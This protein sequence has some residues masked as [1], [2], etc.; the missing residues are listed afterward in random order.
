MWFRPEIIETVNWG[1]DPTKPVEASAGERLRPRHSFARWKEEV[2]GR[3]R[4]WTP[5]DLDAAD[6]LQRRA[7]EVDIERRLSSEQRAV[8]ARDEMLAVVSHDLQ[9]PLSV[10]LLE[11]A[12]VLAHLPQSGDPRAGTLRESVE[13]IRRSTARMKALIEDLLEVE[14]LGEKRFPL[15]VQPVE[16]R[17]LL[18]DAVTEARRLA[19]AKHISL[20]LDL[21]DPPKIDADPHRIS[22]VLANLLGNAIKFTPEGGS[23]TLRARPR[24]GALSV[25]VADTGRGIAPEDLA[26]I[27]DRYWRPKG[28]DRTGSGL[29]L[30]IARGIVEAHGGRVWAEAS[31][32]GA[33]FVFT[34]PLE[35]R[36]N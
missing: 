4:P 15:D 8:R 20:I 3:S 1:G 25:T 30:Y 9:N 28:S 32:Q 17:D 26:H 13:V 12:H 31:P 14:R 7:T 24:D 2:R 23:V 22:Q 29:G 5:S 27:F 33:T 34:L 36:N 10:I 18:E 21:S 6:E 19:D 35:R 11:A 16:S